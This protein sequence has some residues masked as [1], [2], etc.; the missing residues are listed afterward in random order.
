[1]STSKDKQIDKFMDVL[2][3]VLSSS[4]VQT[5]AGIA[6]AFIFNLFEGYDMNRAFTMTEVAAFSRNL[7]LG[8][9][10]IICVA[11]FTYRYVYKA[12]EDKKFFK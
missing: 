3:H 9:Y 5:L 7:F 12:P 6:L 1:M 10:P 4:L 11:Y 8:F 2:P